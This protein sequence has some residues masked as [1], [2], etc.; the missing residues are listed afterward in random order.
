MKAN[1]FRSV[2]SEQFDNR[3]VTRSRSFYDCRI[4]VVS[5]VAIITSSI[6]MLAV[7]S[8]AGP[9]LSTG[10]IAISPGQREGRTS[11]LRFGVYIRSM[12]N[13]ELH[14]L[15]ISRGSCLHQRRLTIIV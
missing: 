13:Q 4:L 9:V 6:Q 10:Q 8:F 1:S 5:R 3:V 12:F 14:C 15:A 7:Y 2:T 11:I